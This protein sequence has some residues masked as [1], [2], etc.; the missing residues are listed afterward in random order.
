MPLLLFNFLG[1]EML[2][3]FVLAL[4]V[5]PFVFYLLSLRNTLRLLSPENQL[6]PPNNV[7]LLFIPIFGIIY[8]FIV[9]GKISDSIARELEQRNLPS[10]ETRPAYNIGLAMC[11]LSVASVI[12]IL[13]GLASFAALIC[14]IIYW[15]KIEGYKG[16]LIRQ[17]TVL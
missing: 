1:P 6:M 4:M 3:L 16:M 17:T 8:H 5:I 14:W 15:L 9:V 13:G 2:I 10:K 11:I 12:P 7:W